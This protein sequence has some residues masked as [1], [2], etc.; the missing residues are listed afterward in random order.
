MGH[1][2]DWSPPKPLSPG[3]VCSTEIASRARSRCSNQVSE[4]EGEEPGVGVGS[5]VPPQT[6]RR[7]RAGYGAH[8]GDGAGERG[9]RRGRTAGRGQKH[10]ECVSSL[11][12]IIQGQRSPHMRNLDPEVETVCVVTKPSICLFVIYLPFQTPAS[13]PMVSRATGTSPHGHVPSKKRGRFR[14]KMRS[15]KQKKRC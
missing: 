15:M 7:R 4:D 2:N 11:H 3:V 13:A 14:F 1:T 6:T 8:A 5:E 9:S 12:V 10:P